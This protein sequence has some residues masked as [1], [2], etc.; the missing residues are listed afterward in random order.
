[1]KTGIPCS[2]PRRK[3]RVTKEY[4]GR[5]QDVAFPRAGKEIEGVGVR[6]RTVEKGWEM[7]RRPRGWLCSEDGPAGPHPSP[8]EH[9]RMLLPREGE[10]R[11]GGSPLL[12]HWQGGAGVGL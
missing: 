9:R 6:V 3:R 1:M 10:R 7:T 11:L 8:A 5:F 2:R 4:S 12:G